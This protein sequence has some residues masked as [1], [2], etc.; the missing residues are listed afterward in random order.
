MH[1]GDIGKEC[2]KIAFSSYRKTFQDDTWLT[3]QHNY[4]LERHENK[5]KLILVQFMVTVVIYS[6]ELFFQYFQMIT[7]VL[8]CDQIFCLA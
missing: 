2:Y 6:V 8:I 5:Y 1:L 3:Y 4:H 7:I